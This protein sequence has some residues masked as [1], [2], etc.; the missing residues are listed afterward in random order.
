MQTNTGRLILTP[1]DPYIAIDKTLLTDAIRKFGLIGEC[2]N[3][4]VNAFCA[5]DSFMQLI[6]FAGCSPFLR[7]EPNSSD[8]ADFCH[9]RLTLLDSN[10]PPL[11]LLGT[12]TKPPACPHCRQPLKEW[13][14]VIDHWKTDEKPWQCPRCHEKVDIPRLNWRKH[15]GYG[16]SLVEIYSVFPG[17]AVPVSSLLDKMAQALETPWHYFYIQDAV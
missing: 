6:T 16:R 9:I 15:G 4:P 10:T 8:D 2:L 17:E 7:F 13:R 5:G 3:A 11:Q 1:I 14:G 12:N